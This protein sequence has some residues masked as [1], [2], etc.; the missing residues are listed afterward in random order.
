MSKATMTKL[1]DQ[2]AAEKKDTPEMCI[3]PME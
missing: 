2:D 1:F 3:K